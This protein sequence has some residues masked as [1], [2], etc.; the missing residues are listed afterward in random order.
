L[1]IDDFSSAAAINADPEA[2]LWDFGYSV[3]L[4]SNTPRSGGMNF[5][6]PFKSGSR[7]GAES[8]SRNDNGINRHG[9]AE[10]LSNCRFQL[11]NPG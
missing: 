7:C 1:T 8:M 3:Y 11:R 9:A 2:G 4:Q 5:G 6:L 10:A